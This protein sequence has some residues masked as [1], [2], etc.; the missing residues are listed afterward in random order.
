V[1]AAAG[2]L[3]NSVF[4]LGSLA[5][6]YGDE[7]VGLLG[8]G[9]SAA[10]ILGTFIGTTMLTNALPE[11]IASAIICVPVVAALQAVFYRNKK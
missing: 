4:V 11:V 3:A 10:A 6:I 9:N 8:G 5:L 2:T 1:G 7:I